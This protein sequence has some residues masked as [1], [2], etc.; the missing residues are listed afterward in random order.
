MQ[1]MIPPVQWLMGPTL[2][3]THSD[4]INLNIKLTTRRG[5]L[6]PEIL[7]TLTFTECHDQFSAFLIM[8]KLEGSVIKCA[9][10]LPAMQ[11]THPH[12][13]GFT[14]TGTCTILPLQC[15]PLNS[16]LRNSFYCVARINFYSQHYPFTP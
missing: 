7:Q 14:N 8:L 6:P 3:I 11:H 12:K 5:R 9:C 15:T 4:I 16:T 10:T 2:L 13:P 1:Q